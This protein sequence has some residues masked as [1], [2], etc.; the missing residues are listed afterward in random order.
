MT[1]KAKINAFVSYAKN[2]KGRERGEA[3]V[4]CDRL[5]QAF[6]HDGY[7]EAGAELEFPIKARGKHPK[8]ADLLWRP[9]LLLEMKTRGED[10]RKHYRQAF[11][12]WMELV[13]ER[14]RYVVLCNFDEF[15][16]YD[17]DYQLEEPVDTVHIEELTERYRVLSFLFP[18]EQR[19]QFK[20]DR[21]DVTRKAAKNVATVFNS[22][23]KR[24]E[25]R[26]RA[27]R[28]TLQCVVAFFAE[29]V[30]LLPKGFFTDILYEC[31]E[32]AS[33]YDL[34]GNLF[35]Q[36]NSP[37]KARGG[38]FKEIAY[39]NGGIFEVVEPIDLK[40]EEVQ[41]LY[42]AAQENWS[43]VKPPIFGT[44][45]ESSIG[46]D[47]RHALGAH[48]TSEA[49]IEQIVI[50]TIER[51]WRMRIEKASSLK[52]LAQLRTELARFRILDPACGSGNFLY[53]AYQTLKRLETE[54]LAKIFENFGEKGLSGVG[55]AS[56]IKTK[57]FY[58]IDANQFAV[59]LAKVTLVL[60]KEI[61]LKESLESGLFARLPLQLEQPLPLDNLD[62]NIFCDDALF[63]DWPEADAII[64]NPPYQ[65]KN[66]MQQEMDPA[67][68]RR[69]RKAYPEV[70]GRADYCVYWFRRAH[71]ELANGGRAG[72][73]G[74]NTIRQNWSREGGLQYIVKNGGTIVEAVSSQAWSGEANVNVSIVNWVKGSAKG[75]KRLFVQ[76]DEKK[77]KWRFE[78]LDVIN[79]ALSFGTDV[80]QARLLKANAK[81]GFCYQGQTHGHKGFLLKPGEAAKMLVYNKKNSE[82]IFPFP[83]ADQL[84]KTR[85]RKC[86]RYVIDFH[87]RDVHRAA[88]HKEPFERIKALVLPKREEEAKKEE[89]RNKKILKENPKANVNHHHKNFLSK[90]WL[91]SYARE[92]LISKI[93]DVSRY[94]V[95]AQVTKRPIFEFLDSS[96]RPNAALIVFAIEDDYSFGILQSTQHWQWFMARCSTLTE[97]FRYTSDTV[98][99]SFPWPQAPKARNVEEVAEAARKLRQVR[100]KL[101]DENGLSLRDVYRSLELPGKNILKEAQ[102]SLDKAVA[103]A[104]GMNAK[105]DVLK[106]LLQLNNDLAT[107]ETEGKKIVG[108][109]IPSALKKTAAKIKSID[110]FVFSDSLV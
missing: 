58:G 25:E 88:M 105:E 71:D 30:E 62:E 34:I 18:K 69:V 31:K 47:E 96:I 59:E 46:K 94:I 27:Q 68:V 19:P 67:Y 79:S 73:V 81:S 110:R 39:F 38:R 56:L 72:L 35:R 42:D 55:K 15:W 106:F 17:F 10:L 12:Y 64:G 28:F 2:L 50:P 109:G 61:S 32:G 16:I 87:P 40:G 77:N 52:D 102:A 11:E 48:F 22:L 107:L 14:P 36:M 6:G 80:T 41:L 103:R 53:I 24:G 100:K 13:P 33:T 82:V 75:Q 43:K 20:N 89:A 1:T 76:L 78:D 5:F 98:F 44:L 49:H 101:M 21:V 85:D 95:C 26:D 9:R 7:K 99:D 29:D 97:R 45:F 92:E 63:C 65:S 74:T 84:F 86:K 104:Y 70:P 93:S 91:L 4:F 51:P 108:P 8:F 90:W 83:N 54:L 3:Q 23:V 57:Q 66:K 37:R 60:A